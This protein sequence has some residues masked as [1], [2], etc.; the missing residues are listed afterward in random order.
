MSR[1]SP[2]KL[3]ILGMIAKCLGLLARFFKVTWKMALRTE[4]G[5][6]EFQHTKRTNS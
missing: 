4:F 3:R 6:K 1:L 2:K 5:P